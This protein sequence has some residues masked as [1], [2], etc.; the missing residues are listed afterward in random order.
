M[1]V[2]AQMVLAAGHRGL[3]PI[4]IRSMTRGG[5]IG[6]LFSRPTLTDRPIGYLTLYLPAYQDAPV[7]CF[8]DC[9]EHWLADLCKD[10]FSIHNESVPIGRRT[11][12]LVSPYR[13][14]YFGCPALG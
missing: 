13:S 4:I 6:E 14:K 12:L 8:L 1:G 9:C 10:R 5:P 2:R 3:F 11:S 7:G